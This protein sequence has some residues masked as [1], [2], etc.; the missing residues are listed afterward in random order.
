[1]SGAVQ[2]WAFKRCRRVRATA[3]WRRR[4]CLLNVALAWLPVPLFVLGF[5]ALIGLEEL[6]QESLIDER[7]GL[8]IAPV[9]GL[10]VLGSLAIMIRCVSE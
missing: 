6:L 1:M 10:S 8:L 5:A 2:I 3:P 4:R 7:A 9:V